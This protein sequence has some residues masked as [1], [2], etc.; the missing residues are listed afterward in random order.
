MSADVCHC[1]FLFYRIS[2]PFENTP[3]CFLESFF[4]QFSGRQSQRIFAFFLISLMSLSTSSS[5]LSGIF[6]L[7]KMQP[8]IMKVAI[9]AKSIK[10]TIIRHFFS[11]VLYYPLVRSCVV[12]S[13][14]YPNHESLCCLFTTSSVFMAKSVALTLF[15]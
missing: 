6:P 13:F 14:P 8:T 15:L 5:V 11:E 2:Y 4:P 9:K 1:F 10:V 7:K 3:C 12:L